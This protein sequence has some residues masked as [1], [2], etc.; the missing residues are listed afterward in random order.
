MTRFSFN[1]SE[2]AKAIAP[3]YR[4]RSR[5]PDTRCRTYHASPELIRAINA[6]DGPDANAKLHYLPPVLKGRILR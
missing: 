2:G 1:A 4:A 3:Q 5:R 6:I